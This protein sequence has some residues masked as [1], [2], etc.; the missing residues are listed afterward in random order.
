MPPSHYGFVV[1]SRCGL[2]QSLNYQFWGMGLAD[3]S[4]FNQ[5]FSVS[6]LLFLGVFGEEG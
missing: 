3:V 4:L 2:Q 5:S 1:T 6:D